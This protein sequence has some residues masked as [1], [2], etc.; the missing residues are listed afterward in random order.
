[1]GGIA[2]GVLA[3]GKLQFKALVAPDVVLPGAT[4]VDDEQVQMQRPGW[5]GLLADW[6][7]ELER[8]AAGYLAGAA[9]VAPKRTSSCQYCPLPLLCRLDARRT[10][11]QRLGVDEPGADAAA[12]D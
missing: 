7:D 12:E 8:L 9:E 2:F 1:M 6:R 4:V 5:S 11:A 10:E 3:P